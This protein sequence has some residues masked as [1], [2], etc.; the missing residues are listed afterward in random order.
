M[1]KWLDPELWLRGGGIAALMLIALVLAIAYGC[2]VVFLWLSPQI[3]AWIKAHITHVESSVKN[4]ERLTSTVET[5]SE[6]LGDLCPRIHAIAE[7]HKEGC[8]AMSKSIKD[9]EIRASVEPHFTQI[10]SV[11]RF[12]PT[13]KRQQAKE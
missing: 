8:E 7:A 9:P 13:P 3:D 6:T 11:L 12:Q 1:D 10:R 2:R 4:N 5:L